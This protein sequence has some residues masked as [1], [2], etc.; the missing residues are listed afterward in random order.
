MIVARDWPMRSDSHRRHRSQNCLFCALAPPPSP[1]FFPLQTFDQFNNLLWPLGIAGSS[2]SRGAGSVVVKRRKNKNLERYR[3]HLQFPPA[4]LRTPELL[5][6]DRSTEAV[7]CK[8]TQRQLRS[9]EYQLYQRPSFHT[10]P[11]SR[12]TSR[13]WKKAARWAASRRILS[14]FSGL[15][16][17]RAGGDTWYSVH[18]S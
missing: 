2:G 6:V 12:K 14:A 3:S 8:V 5:Q 11:R 10:G 16:P 17:A 1:P 4:L 13:T 9:Q 15:Y 7:S 18:V